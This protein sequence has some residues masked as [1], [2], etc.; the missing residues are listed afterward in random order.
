MAASYRQVPEDTAGMPGGVPY[1][2][3][4]E[5]AER[6]SYYGMK[7][8]LV[9]FMTHHLHNI[10]GGIAPMS[11]EEAKAVF[12]L[13]SAGAYFFPL[14]GAILADVFWGKY[15]TIVLLS[16][17]YCMGH[18]A[19]AFDETRVGLV[20]GLS[21]IAVGAGGIKPCV[22]A[23]VG[24]QFG[25]QNQN[26]LERVFGWF[27]FSIN[28]GSFVSTLL[29]PILLE[30]YGS[31]LAFGVP[32][33][34]MVV[35]TLV[36]WM[37]RGR[38]AHVPPAGAAF[39]RELLSTQGLALLGRLGGLILFIA[40]FWAL[41]E[42]NGSA[43]VLQAGRMDRTLFGIEW[44]PSQIQAVNPILV[45]LFIPLTSYIIYP[46][47]S[48]IF[49]L[50]ALRKISIGFFLM[51]AAFLI[52][53]YIEARLSSGA[54]MNIV[55]QIVAYAVLTLAEVLV[56]GTGLE[57]FYTQAPNRMKSLVMGFFLLSVSIGNAFTSLVNLFIV[58][59]DGTTRLGGAPYYLFFAS[60]MLLTSLGFVLYASRYREHRHL[61]GVSEPETD[62]V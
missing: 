35:A 51:V 48:K 61:Q 36:F 14:L 59:P 50:T 33:V 62:A 7:T 41:Y 25:A 20:V 30:R 5:L 44:L 39:G 15:R 4:N 43:W 53:A 19:L 6:F 26:L 37:G 16:L 60:L 49:P 24:D 46:A 54:Q 13:F 47:V 27:Y 2:V 8:I 21:L 9:V 38:F 57:F 10:H 17:V 55:W 45:L 29:T 3:S 28:L 18:F 32:G 56:Y 40:M 34:L 22:S 58:R 31:K 42:Q 12:H 11:D 52:S 1:I 23:H